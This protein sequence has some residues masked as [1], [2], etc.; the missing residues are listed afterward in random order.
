[1][2]SHATS[3]YFDI[4][5][6]IDADADD[7]GPIVVKWLAKYW[8]HVGNLW[9]RKRIVLA[10]GGGGGGGGGERQSLNPG[11]Q[12][13][14]YQ[15]FQGLLPHGFPHRAR[16]NGCSV[17]AV[18]STRASKFRRSVLGCIEAE[19]YNVFKHHLNALA[20][21]YQLQCSMHIFF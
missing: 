14:Q 1:M 12:Q 16:L 18:L 20:K 15:A 2:L 21:I 3:Q 10:R 9:R 4:I 5:C 7:H 19:A 11:R 13:S 6:K 17:S 8:R